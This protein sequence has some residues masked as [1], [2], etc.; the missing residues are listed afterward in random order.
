MKPINL[1]H[2]K[3]STSNYDYSK[4][5]EGYELRS[6]HYEPDRNSDWEAITGIRCHI[7]NVLR[8]FL[9]GSGKD[10]STFVQGTY[11]GIHEHDYYL[12][13]H[14]APNT[15][16]FLVPNKDD[17]VVTH[18]PKFSGVP[19]ESLARG[20]RAS[21]GTSHVG[22]HRDLYYVYYEWDSLVEWNSEAVRE[23][24]EYTISNL[25]IVKQ[26]CKRKHLEKKE[27]EKKQTE[28]S[29]HNWKKDSSISI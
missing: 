5:L 13:K 3:V 9:S 23:H 6:G 26:G 16:Q 8:I 18:I 20:F 24:I 11:I 28:N 29:K 17:A 22:L 25:G 2:P 4:D 7:S 21:G 15:Y 1:L 19:A 10:S 27:V 14:Y 12:I